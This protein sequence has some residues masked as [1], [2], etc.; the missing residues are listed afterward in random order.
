MGI[1]AAAPNIPT[2]PAGD[3]ANFVYSSAQAGNAPITGTGQ[4]DAIQIFGPCNLLIYASGGPN[5]AWVGTVRLERS[6]DGGTT[7]IVCGIGGAGQQAIWN[8][9]T[10]I[11]A[12]IGEP[13]KGVLYRLN[14][15]A[16]TSGT[17]NWRFSTNGAAAMSLSLAAVI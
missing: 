16:W 11:S 15:T 7:W 1:P 6:F 10:D 4:T 17:I 5:G 12:V 13:E 2:P 8:T 14:C 9:G 3:K